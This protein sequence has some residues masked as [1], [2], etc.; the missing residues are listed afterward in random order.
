MARIFH[1]EYYLIDV[2]DEWSK[3]DL[4]RELFN[5]FNIAP[6]THFVKESKEF[7]WDDDLP[8]NVMG[9]PVEEFKKYFGE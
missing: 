7:K 1:G 3:E 6:D 4:I 5:K 9:C 8:I 2:N